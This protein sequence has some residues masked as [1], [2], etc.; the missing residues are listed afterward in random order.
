MAV[1]KQLALQPARTLKQA[2]R[3][4]KHTERLLERRDVVQAR[5]RQDVLLPVRLLA[6]R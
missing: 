4:V 6:Q 5:R 3:L 1:A 2:L